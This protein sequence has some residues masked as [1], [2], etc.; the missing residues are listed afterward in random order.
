MINPSL[1]VEP[2]EK[3]IAD[4]G[5][6]GLRGVHS[7]GKDIKWGIS[8]KFMNNSIEPYKVKLRKTLNLES[9]PF[10]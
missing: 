3:E 8:S 2:V 10:L 1:F 6:G 4:A 5:D 9:S 7:E